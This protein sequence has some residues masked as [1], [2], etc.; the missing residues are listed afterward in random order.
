MRYLLALYPPLEDV[1]KASLGT[2]AE[3]PDKKKNDGFQLRDTNGAKCI[4]NSNVEMAW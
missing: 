3:I 2:F 4:T 1:A